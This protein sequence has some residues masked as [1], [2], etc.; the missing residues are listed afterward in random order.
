MG[1]FRQDSQQLQQH[2]ENACVFLSQRR[3][4]RA[5]QQTLGFGVL[6]HP[7][8]TLRRGVDVRGDF[9]ENNSSRCRRQ[10][11]SS[12]AEEGLRD[13]T[14]RRLQGHRPETVGR[15]GTSVRSEQHAENTVHR[16]HSGISSH[17]THGGSSRG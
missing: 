6:Q 15:H 10:I 2:S 12:A 11:C 16:V 17:G 13:G 7:E 8:H 3:P 9:C 1:S 5:S 4:T 14:I